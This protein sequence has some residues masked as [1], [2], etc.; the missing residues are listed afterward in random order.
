MRIQAHST[1][2]TRRLQGALDN[3]ETLKFEVHDNGGRPFKVIVFPNG[4][5]R[6]HVLP[7]IGQ[8]LG[9]RVLDVDATLVCVGQGTWERPSSTAAWCLGNTVLIVSARRVYSVA[10]SICTFSLQPR[11]RVVKFMSA[12]GNSD[13]PYGY[14]ETSR[15]VYAVSSFN[16]DNGFLPTSL[17][18]SM[19]LTDLE[20][21]C[22]SRRPPRDLIESGSQRPV[23]LRAIRDLAVLVPRRR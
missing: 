16:C 10:S 22:M 5:V 8:R 4:R 21:S 6:V 18:H 12:V 3:G 14:L 15:G 1:S 23:P 2:V 11:E 20:L 13:V 7:L 17:V 19:G 9:R